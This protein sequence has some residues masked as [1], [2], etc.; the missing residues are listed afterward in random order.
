MA[1]ITLP[2]KTTANLRR[3]VDLAN[4]KPGVVLT[5]QATRGTYLLKVVDPTKA[6]VEVNGTDHR[7]NGVVAC[8]VCSF[9]GPERSRHRIRRPGWIGHNM[10]MQLRFKNFLLACDPTVALRVQGEGWHYEVF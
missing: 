4:L 8:L 2:P 1:T 9:Y 10:R 6:L 3:G 7:M 5:V